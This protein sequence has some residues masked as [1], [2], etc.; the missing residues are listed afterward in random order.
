MGDGERYPD[1]VHNGPATQKSR[2]GAACTCADNSWTDAYTCMYT[3]CKRYMYSG[4]LC[5]VCVICR[6]Y[7]SIN[8]AVSI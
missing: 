1:V 2:R 4:Y 3:P 5:N 8:A 7:R 6:G